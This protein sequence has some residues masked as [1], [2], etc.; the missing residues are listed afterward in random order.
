L[1]GK[2]AVLQAGAL[3]CWH[4]WVCACWRRRDPGLHCFACIF[5]RA[6]ACVVLRALVVSRMEGELLSEGEPTVAARQGQGAHS[7]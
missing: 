5:G 1:Q 4:A 3:A 6:H 2:L 7:L